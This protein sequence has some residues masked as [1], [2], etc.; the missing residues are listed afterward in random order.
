MG[1][2]GVESMMHGFVVYPDQEDSRYP[3]HRRNL[4]HGQE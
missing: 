4:Y 2:G 1:A 3:P